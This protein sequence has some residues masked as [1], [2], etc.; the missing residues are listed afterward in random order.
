MSV[1]VNGW[2]AGYLWRRNGEENSA[3]LGAFGLLAAGRNLIRSAALHLK[4]AES[5]ESR[6]RW[7]LPTKLQ[8]IS[9]KRSE[10]EAKI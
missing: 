9:M 5:E 8:K 4:R 2:L 10:S 1:W 7:L 6:R 3:K